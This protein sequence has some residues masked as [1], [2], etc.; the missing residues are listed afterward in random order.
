MNKRIYGLFTAVTMIT[1]IVIGSGIFFK[2]DD[3]LS[4]TG[5]N[6]LLGIIVF[7]VAAVAIVFGCLAISQLATRTDKPGGLIAYAQEFVS[8]GISSAFGWFQTFLY[9]P[10]LAAV[11]SWV[12]GI[13][14][15]QLFG[16]NASLEIQIFIGIV[17]LT[18]LFVINIL[19]AR[20]GGHVQNASMI[21]KLI[22]LIIIAVAGLI[23][24]N[25]QEFIAQ[26]INNFGEATTSFGWLAAFAP[27]AFSFDGW[28]VSTSICHEIKNSKRNLPLAL[29]VSPFIILLAYAAYFVGIV[30]MVGPETILEQKDSSVFLVSEM[31]FGRIGAKILLIFV[32]ISVIGTV[33]GIVLGFIRMP[34]SLALRNMIP[35]SKILA[36][37]HKNL[38]GM[39]LNSALFAYVLSIGWM[40]VHYL[41]Q[42]LGMRGDVSEI[43]IG[44]SYLN[45]ILLYYAVIRL[46]RKGSIQSI[47]KG[48]I[49]PILAMGGSLVIISGSITHPLFVYY[50]GICFIIMLAGVLYYEKNK[51]K[52]DLPR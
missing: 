50:A 49:I 18:L 16:I 51:D 47:F 3:I 41:S 19:S 38:G 30:S 34:Y 26:D 36:K 40:L 48:Y 31:I 24:G 33:N 6:I 44:I 15:C 39:P 22:P 42:K 13:F 17:S 12:I 8:M 14:T 23:F 45:Y 20:L 21:I 52:I 35:G 29:T 46:A 5:G 43:A 27:I 1:G 11:V 4:Y 25:P 28:I 10:T 32:I 9:L 37:E 7:F 2:S